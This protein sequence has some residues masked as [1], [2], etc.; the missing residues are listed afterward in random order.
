[1][2]SVNN[3]DS[4]QMKARLFERVGQAFGIKQDDYKSLFAYGSAIKKAVDDLKQKS[5]SA[6][7]QIEKKLGLDELGVSLDT[8]V[9]AVVD[10]QGSDGDKLDAALKKSLGEHDKGKDKGVSPQPDEIGVYGR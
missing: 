10:P 5:P 8:L 7:T 3:T 4:T 6:V 2:F 1:M 9:N